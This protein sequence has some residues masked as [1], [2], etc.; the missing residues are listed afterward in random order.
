MVRVWIGALSPELEAR[1]PQRGLMRDA[2]ACIYVG[3][4]ARYVGSI[5][6][7]WGPFVDLTQWTVW[8]LDGNTLLQGGIEKVGSRIHQ[9]VRAGNEIAVLYGSAKTGLL[10][11]EPIVE[12]AGREYR[13]PANLRETAAFEF[14][15]CAFRWRRS[16]SGQSE[17]HFYLSAG[18]ELLAFVGFAYDLW[19]GAYLGGK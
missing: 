4:D 6:G 19:K 14:G 15:A 8:D 10:K 3:G 16:A 5:T 7:S 13:V 12:I 9:L 17:L 11:S 2:R 18:E 1:F